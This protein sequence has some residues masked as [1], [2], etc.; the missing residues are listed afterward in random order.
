MGIK[1]R[2]EKERRI[3]K[4]DIVDAAERVFFAK[5]FERA[6]M[7]DVAAEAE[8]SKRTLY[9]YFPGKEQLYMAFML[10]AFQTLNKLIQNNMTE[11]ASKNGIE[12]LK[13]IMDTWLPDILHVSGT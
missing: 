8:F 1:E 7:D 13:I 10:R 11:K 4:D 9:T 12:K 2:K 6:T 3:R 5:G